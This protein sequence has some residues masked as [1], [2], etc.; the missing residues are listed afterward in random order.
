[1]TREP[2]W[3]MATVAAPLTAADE[4]ESR[5]V[6]KVVTDRRGAA[7]YFSRAVI[8]FL[9]D[10]DRAPADLRRLRHIG[11]YAYR[12]A[13]LQ[14]MVAARPCMLERS[15]GLEQLRALYLGARIKVVV[16]AECRSLGVD[17]PADI[18][19]AEAALRS[20]GLAE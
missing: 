2:H 8:P 9:R 18:P 4:I 14:R 13:C 12:R 10:A 19:R 3:D 11:L 17:V 5:S 15:E 7:L 1:M 16:A 20:A 6:V